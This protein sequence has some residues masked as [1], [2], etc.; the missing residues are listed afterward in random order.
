MFKMEQYMEEN[1]SFITLNNEK[2]RS[3]LTICLTQGGMVTEL[4]VN[5]EE[6][7]YLN[8]ATLFDESRPIRG[9]IPVLFPTSG[10]LSNDSYIWNEQEY[11]MPVH[12]FARDHTWTIV[13][14]AL[15]EE[16][17][18]IT[19]RLESSEEMLKLYP[20]Q[21]ELLFTYT[22]D[23]DGL[24]IDQSYQNNTSEPMPIHPGFHPYFQTDFNLIEIDAQVPTYLDLHDNQEKA[25]SGSIKKQDLEPS[26]VFTNKKGGTVSVQT[27]N[28]QQVIMEYGPEFKYTVF[29]TEEGGDFV[30]MEPWVA[31]PN[32]INEKK[33]LVYVQ[34]NSS[35]DTFATFKVK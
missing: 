24:T 11:H 14:T 22:V 15:E 9:G 25:W 30:C 27:K 32:A 6:I 16:T 3:W 1:N 28:D 18:S 29:W 12:G 7:L 20:F 35:I 19:L 4:G 21:F 26:I 5:G 23:A 2:L 8:K 13:S 33:G 34:P 31:L 10:K 17:A